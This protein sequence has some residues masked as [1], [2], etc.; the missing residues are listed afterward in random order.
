MS[1]HTS[2]SAFSWI[3]REA[4]VWRTC[5]VSSPVSTLH[6]LTQPT[7]S[8]VNSMSPFPRE[9]RTNSVECWQMGIGRI[10]AETR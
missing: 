6:D 4:L 3:T 9:L 10:L 8:W 7:T 1:R 2:G 5:S